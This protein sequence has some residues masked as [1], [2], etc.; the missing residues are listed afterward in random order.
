MKFIL[1]ILLLLILSQVQA[2]FFEKY[3][4]YGS[5]ELNVGN[6][7]GVDLNL[8]LVHNENY[9]FKIGYTGNIREPRTQP[10]DYTPGLGALF[11]FG[12][13]SPF[14]SFE[15]HQLTT[16]KI[17]RLNQSGTARMNFA[18]GVGL[19]TIRE[20][21]NWESVDFFFFGEN[22]TWNYDTQRTISFIIN[23]K[24]EFP[25]TDFFG[26]TVS[27]MIQ[28]NETRTYLGIGIGGMLGSLRSSK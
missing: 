15:S 14:D 26:F 1:S 27:P 22:Y 9:S 23:P 21:E 5:G 24:F 16:G 10:E 3:A 8:N 11:T 4:L 2:Q 19:T 17:F 20:P 28:I 6:Y 25:F 18:V 7:M 12:L 13:S